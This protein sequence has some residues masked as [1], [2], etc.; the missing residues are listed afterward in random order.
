MFDKRAYA[1]FSVRGS[2]NIKTESDAPS[3]FEGELINIG[4]RG[5]SVLL[6][7]KIATGTLVQ[8]ELLID[9]YG[10]PLIGRAKVRNVREVK[11]HGMQGFELG[12]EFIEVNE[13]L[14]VVILHRIRRK[15]SK[16]KHKR[17]ASRPS[18][19]NQYDLY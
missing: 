10:E 17:A 16:E 15:I 5:F 1:R 13:Y 7:E 9:V 8:F 19:V 3:I 18:G 12:V 14:I 11:R 4:F 2:V 6:N